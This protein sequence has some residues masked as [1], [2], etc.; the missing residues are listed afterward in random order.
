MR[1][2]ARKAGDVMYPTAKPWENDGA[3]GS[4]NQ[5]RQGRHPATVNKLP[6]KS[7]LIPPLRG[8][9]VFLCPFTHGSAPWAQ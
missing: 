7:I 2:K 4:P 8:C 1:E 9:K 5:P 6:T 3:P